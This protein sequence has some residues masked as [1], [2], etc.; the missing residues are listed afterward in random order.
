M[1]TF[2]IWGKALW[3]FL[4]T[5]SE[6]IQCD[7]FKKERD[8]ILS[9]IIELMNNIPCDNCRSHAIKY[10][11][12]NNFRRIQSKVELKNFFFTF[13]NQINVKKNRNLFHNYDIYKTYS[14]QKVMSYFRTYFV[15][16]RS[17]KMLFIHNKKRSDVGTKMIAFVN[18]NLNYFT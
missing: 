6:K 10:L 9:L 11:K 16:Y 4:H 2:Q 8:T 1:G 7:F 18:N 5:F 15:H 12:Q 17:N 13:H 14:V 3:I